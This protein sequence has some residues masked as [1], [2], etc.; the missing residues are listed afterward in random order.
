M[1]IEGRKLSMDVQFFVS[2]ISVKWNR[3]FFISQKE[4]RGLF[5]LFEIDVEELSILS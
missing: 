5:I 1:N 3:V 2:P 4:F